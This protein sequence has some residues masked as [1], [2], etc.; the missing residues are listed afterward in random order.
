MPG[1]RRRGDG[2]SSGSGSRAAASR[3]R[4]RCR[5]RARRRPGSRPRPRRAGP[6]PRRGR[7]AG[8]GPGRTDR[9]TSGRARRGRRRCPAPVARPVVSVSRQTSGTSGGAPSGSRPSRSRSIGR[10]ER[11]RLD[12]DVAARRRRGPT[13]R[14]RRRRAAR[15]ARRSA[16][17]ARPAARARCAPRRGGPPIRP[18]SAAAGVPGAPQVRQPAP[19]PGRVDHAADGRLDGARRCAGAERA[20]QPQGECLGVDVRVRAA[21]RCR[22]GSPTRSRSRRSARPPRRRARPSARTAAR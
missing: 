21:G 22:P 7:A 11:R 16:G 8:A 14:R 2:G 13:P 19:E 17:R 1:V 6:A 20:E 4:A 5:S 15:R 12:P 18:R 3:S 9:P 10:L